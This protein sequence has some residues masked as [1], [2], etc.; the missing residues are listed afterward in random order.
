MAKIWLSP[1]G[2]V[3]KGHVL[4]VAVKPF[5]RALKDYDR[6]LYVK[7]NPKKLKG[8]GCWEIRRKPESL[9]ITDWAEVGSTVVFKLDYLENNLISH[10]LDCAFL[11]YSQLNKIRSMDTF[12]IGPQQ[13]IAD[14]E[15]LAKEQ[16]LARQAAAKQ[17]LSYAAKEFKREMRDFKELVASGFNPHRVLGE[18]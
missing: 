6:Q 2:A 4:D 14:R 8:W 1:T 13:W 15:H 17:E 5:E 9:T 7:W 16:K 10:V 11:N 3:T 18:W 12:Q